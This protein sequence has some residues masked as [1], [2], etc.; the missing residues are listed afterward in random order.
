M[1]VGR[2]YQVK[3]GN[4]VTF[5]CE[6]RSASDNDRHIR[7]HD[8]SGGQYRERDPH[9]EEGQQADQRRPAGYQV[10]SFNFVSIDFFKSPTTAHLHY[11]CFGIKQ[12][13]K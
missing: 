11:L 5:H 8:M 13:L 6:V 1:S 2:T 12:A 7:H 9:L 4:P 3:R 10:E